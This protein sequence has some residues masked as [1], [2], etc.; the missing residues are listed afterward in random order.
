MLQK[1]CFAASTLVV[2][3]QQ[4][5]FNKMKSKQHITKPPP[6][7][8]SPTGAGEHATGQHRQSENQLSSWKKSAS[9]ATLFFPQTQHHWLEKKKNRKKTPKHKKSTKPRKTK[10][11]LQILSSKIKSKQQI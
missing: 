11:K 9:P 1:E 3:H 5:Q 8:P 2:T 10:P 6:A 7:N 4:A